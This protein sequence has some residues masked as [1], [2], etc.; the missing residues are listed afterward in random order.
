M[1]NIILLLFTL[2]FVSIEAQ[3]INFNDPFSNEI[4]YINPE[5]KKF[6]SIDKA[7]LLAYYK[8]RFDYTLTTL[9]DDFKIVKTNS[10]NEEKD[11]LML[12][13]KFKKG[14]K[15]ISL[16][17]KL[18]QKDKLLLLMGEEC[19]CENENCEKHNCDVFTFCACSP[20]EKDKNGCR[21]I[22][23]KIKLES[24]TY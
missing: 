22:N 3:T 11:N 24:T 4:G 7:R 9:I 18:V 2:T 8:K 12:L 5:T 21:K 13:V 17:S 16:A 15:I 14:T 19:I 10:K 6:V 23:T 20:C 1:K